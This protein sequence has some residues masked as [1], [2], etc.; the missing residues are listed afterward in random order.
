MIG[1]FFSLCMPA[2]NNDFTGKISSNIVL[3]NRLSYL[4]LGKW[5]Y[6]VDHLTA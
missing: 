2:D 4:S 1:N 5:K 6:V 3:L